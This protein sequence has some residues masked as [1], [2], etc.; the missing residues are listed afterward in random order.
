MDNSYF[1]DYDAFT[2]TPFSR[3]SIAAVTQ[4]TMIRDIIKRPM[5]LPSGALI[6]VQMI[7]A[8][9]YLLAYLS[10]SSAC[11]RSEAAGSLKRRKRQKNKI[12][13]TF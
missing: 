1:K 2:F 7:L 13:E 5:V 4:P 6:F 3:K 11:L 12:T 8:P 9:I 10:L